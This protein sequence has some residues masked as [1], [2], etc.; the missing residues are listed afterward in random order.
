MAAMLIISI[1]QRCHAEES[2]S[3]GISLDEIVLRMEQ[4]T[5]QAKQTGPFLLT[6]EYRMY[7][8][9]DSNPASEVKAEIN[10]VPPHE[11]DYKIVESHGSD[12]GEKVVRKILDHE[13]QAD[14]TNP[15]PMAVVRQNYEFQYAA[16]DT[17]QGA[18]CYV[19]T[20]HAKRKDPSLVEGK[21]WVDANT[22]LIRKVE[23]E[24]S[25]S[26]SWWVKE[27]KL[28]VQFGKIG[29]VWTATASDAVAEVRFLG[30]YTV[31][32]RA[33]EVETSN[34]LAARGKPA[35]KKMFSRSPRQNVPATMLYPGVMPR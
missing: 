2:A 3:P 35:Q 24:L 32:G 1:P 16:E 25:K 30:K 5:A 29:G 22:F 17:Y 13:V 31:N 9:D 10:V 8:G 27:V 26:P 7:H 14:K 18:H 11:R 19:L 12:R 4:A 28:I 6:R 21:A 33:L 20:L 23:G 34:A 15:S